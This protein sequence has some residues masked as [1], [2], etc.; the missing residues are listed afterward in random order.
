VI[1]VRKEIAFHRSLRFK[2]MTFIVAGIG[3]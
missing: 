2:A 3:W 1:L